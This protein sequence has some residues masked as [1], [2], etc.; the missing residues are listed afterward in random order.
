MAKTELD[1]LQ[2]DLDQGVQVAYDVIIIG[3]RCAGASLARL[4]AALGI[5]VL[6]IDKC[7][8]PSDT[9]STHCITLPG[10]HHLA[11]WGLIQ[12]I[13]ATSAPLVQK[14][15]L[16]V[17][18]K[19]WPGFFGYGRGSWT[20]APRRTVLDSILIEEASKA[21]A[22]V[23]QE[24]KVTKVQVNSRRGTQVTGTRKSSGRFEET[25]AIVIGADG[26]RS[27]VA[28]DVAASTEWSRQSRL[29]GWY[30]YYA[31]LPVDTAI[32]AFG[33]SASAGSFPT[34]NGLACV[35]S[36]CDLKA[37]PRRSSDHLT[38]FYSA[39]RASSERL[40]E[41]VASAQIISQL[42]FFGAYPGFM[43]NQFGPGWALIGDASRFSHP[44]TAHG[45]SDAFRDAQLVADAI[46]SNLNGECSW[47][48][49]ARR[50][51]NRQDAT[52]KQAFEITQE[53]AGLNWATTN[54]SDL[55]TAY[56]ASVQT[57]LALEREWWGNVS[58][59][60]SHIVPVFKP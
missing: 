28:H 27:R 5:R 42:T 60:N 26:R 37:M 44:V 18:N 16:E 40:S 9:I 30:A 22:T 38:N 51:A 36:M 47:I 59:N 48:E 29:G 1:Q 19:P 58:F 49:A 25:A 43:R 35:W 50:Y 23:W 7:Q 57:A 33:E 13:I 39:L 41:W 12:K 3:G 53:I 32:W 17:A 8:F 45:I 34:N 21:G 24:T 31:S 15:D 6:L 55:L 11:R 46:Y 14:F 20:L 4:I 10:L 54:I 56:K 52:T 2:I